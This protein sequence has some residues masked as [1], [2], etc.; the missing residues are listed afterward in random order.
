MGKPVYSKIDCTK[1]MLR[2]FKFFNRSFTRREYDSVTAIFSRIVEKKFGSWRKALEETGLLKKFEDFKSIKKEIKNFNPQAQV[3]TEWDDEKK[4]L[5]QNA[6]KR[7]LKVFKHKKYKLDLLT[8][9]VKEA[10]ATLKVSSIRVSPKKLPKAS[11]KQAS[12][13]LWFEFSDSQLGTLLKSDEVANLN[14]YNWLIWR[15][16]LNAWKD[17]VI[18]LID[19]HATAFTLDKIVIS[20]LGDFVEGFDIFKGQVWSIEKNVVDQAIHGAE[21]V[22]KALS[23][24]F[25][26]FPQYKFHL[27]EVFGNHGRLGRKGET[28]YSNSMDK[29]FLRFLKLRLESTVKNF[30]YYE[31]ESWFYLVN[32][33]GWNHL[34]LHGDQG[35]SAMW[36]S[37]PTI[38]SLEKGI[39]RYNQMLQNQI[40]FV[41]VGHYHQ[42]WQISFNASQ[43]LINGSFVGTSKFSASQLVSGSAPVQTMHVFD[44][45]FGLIRTVRIHL[46]TDDIKLRVTPNKID[47]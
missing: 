29:V 11:N 16:E 47:N 20:F 21:D 27:L 4:K 45:K 30:V 18:A 17:K 14:E 1:E 37:R 31:N 43:M 23:E 36:S 41:H 19:E 40:H 28:P 44:P 3:K 39:V 12:C 7:N 38:N 32:V 34:L 10:V 8:E 25:L 5:I 15:Q 6:E 42:D 35:M 2:V 33:Y 26:T 13:M 22:A 46:H 24:I 9:M